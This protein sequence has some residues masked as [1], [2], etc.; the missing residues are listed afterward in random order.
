MTLSDNEVVVQSFLPHPLEFKRDGEVILTIPAGYAERNIVIAPT[1]LIKDLVAND[2]TLK[3]AYAQ[4]LVKILDNVPV[5]YQD[6]ADTIIQM[7][8]SL[9]KE[10]TEKATATS[11]LGAALSEI[12]LLKKHIAELEAGTAIA[13]VDPAKLAAAKEAAKKAAQ[14]TH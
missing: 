7:R 9:E 13:G 10:K 8:L 12:E 11:N 14:T 1:E 4:H 6:Q 5:K 3:S 2:T